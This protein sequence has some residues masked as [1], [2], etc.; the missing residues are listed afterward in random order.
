MSTAIEPLEHL[1][2]L[3]ESARYFSAAAERF[4]AYRNNL[5]RELRAAGVSA[6]DI[7]EAAK[8]NRQRVYVILKG[9]GRDADDDVYADFVEHV[10]RLWE[11][12]LARW[13]SSGFEGDADDYFELGELLENAS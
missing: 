9:P 6:F 2:M 13:E 3:S 7:A 8:I 12:A 4:S 5:M 1:A 10:E 11:T